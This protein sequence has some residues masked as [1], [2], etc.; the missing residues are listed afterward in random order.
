VHDFGHFLFQEGQLVLEVEHNFIVFFYRLFLFLSQNQR[1]FFLFE[2]WF[3]GFKT[4]EMVVFVFGGQ[5]T[6]VLS[7]EFVLWRWRF[8]LMH[9]TTF[10]IL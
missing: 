3:G 2:L 7:D 4:V 8:L 9:F 6:F 5:F 1:L 10:K